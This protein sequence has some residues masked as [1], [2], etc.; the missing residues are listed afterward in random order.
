MEQQPLRKKPRKPRASKREHI[1]QSAMQVFCHYGYDGATLQK[2][3]DDAGVSKAL[4]I[5]YYDSVKNVLN[6]CLQQIIKEFDDRI[7]ELT[8]QE[9]ITY[10]Q[11]CDD[12]FAL[13][14]D[15]R[16]KLKLLVSILLTPAHE[17][18]CD[19]LMPNYLGG[20]QQYMA[21]FPDMA[22][23]AQKDVVVYTT[24]SLLLGYLLGGNKENY[25][26]SQAEFE[27]HYL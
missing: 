16:P 18:M 21:K 26:K 5:K 9:E 22:V 27:K 8:N 1:L 4:I 10:Q 6:L 3:A 13:F 15:M 11:H 2:I 7:S 12:L 24:Y 14:T 20:F 19:E 25:Q 23:H 17:Q